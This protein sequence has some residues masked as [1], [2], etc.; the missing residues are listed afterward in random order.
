MPSNFRYHSGLGNTAAFQTSAKPYLTSS[1]TV[2]A[3]G[4][5]PLEIQFENVTKFVIITN[6]V[7]AEDTNVPLRFG[8][9]ANGVKGDSNKNY[10]I[11]NNNETFE[12]DFK[13]TTLYLMSD[14]TNQCTASVIAGLTGINI[15]ELGNNWSGSA[16]VG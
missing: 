2:P 1:L 5:E 14:S 4:S 9:S 13:V 8:F 3:S 15:I 12:A 10:G 7:P 16:G 6:T 11:L